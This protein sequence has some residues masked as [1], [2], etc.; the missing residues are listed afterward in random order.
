[1]KNISLSVFF[2]AYNEEINIAKT[3]EQA[4]TVLKKIVKTYEIIIVNDGS[5][6]KTGEIADKLSK[7]DP[8]HI[9]VIHHSP[10][11]GYGAALQ[12][13]FH[14]AK[15][16]Y[17]F[18]SDSDLQ[19]DL[20]EIEKLLE[21]IPKYKV[22]IG[23]R[24]PRRDPFFRL[25]NAALWGL[26][27]RLLFGL[28]VKDIDCAFKLIHRE[29]VKNL[30]M[31]SGGAMLSAEILIRLQNQGIKIKEVPVTHLPSNKTETTGAKPE[32]IIRA[33]RDMWK[34]FNGDLGTPLM[35][36][37]VLFT[38]FGAINTLGDII[39][40]FVLTRSIGW[41]GD[42]LVITKG[43]TFLTMGVSSFFMN[44]SLTFRATHPPTWR[45]YSKFLATNI[46]GLT[47]N[48]TAL[49]I[50]LRAFN[51]MD[52]PA[53]IGAAGASYIWN[54]ST[55]KL[56]VFR[57][58]P[59]GQSIFGKDFLIL[60]FLMVII[61]IN[62][63]IWL[64]FDT[65]P[66][67]WDMANHLRHGLEYTDVAIQIRDSVTLKELARSVFEFFVGKNTYY[68]P[69][70]YWVSVPWILALGRTF[71]AAVLSNIFFLAV[72][73]FSTYT[74]GVRL[75]NRTTGL[76]AT[77]VMLSFPFIVGQFHEFQLDLPL[78]A[79]NL[80]AVVALLKTNR[81]QNRFWSFVFGATVGL[82]MLT[83]WPLPAF[84]IG[85]VV[86]E[87]IGRIREI[88][89]LTG[90]KHREAQQ[91]L[92]LNLGLGLLGW[93]VTAGPWYIRHLESLQSNLGVNWETGTGEGDPNPLSVRSFRLYSD[94][95]IQ[96]QIRLFMLIPFVV[97][98][99]LT[100]K[101]KVN[102]QKN[103]V[104]LAWFAGSYIVMTLYN[105][106][107][108]RFIEPILGSVAILTAF[109]IPQ[110]KNPIKKILIGYIVIIAMFQFWTVSWGQ[111]LLPNTPEW[112]TAYI[113]DIE[114]PIKNKFRLT[115]WQFAGYGSGSPRPENWHQHDILDAIDLTNPDKTPKKFA[116]YYRDDAFFNRE[117]MAYAISQRQAPYSIRD[118]GQATWDCYNV[119]YVIATDQSG[120][121][122]FVNREFPHREG[123]RLENP[124]EYH[125]IPFCNLKTIG[126]YTLPNKHKVTLWQII[127]T[128]PK[129]EPG[130]P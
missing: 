71:E 35:R 56:W 122:Q 86:Y 14:A 70:V 33:F 123:F 109:W 61:I 43:L 21:H 31:E 66:P 129:P 51:F 55:Q 72:M 110:L 77:I 112:V 7:S 27:I 42:H 23:Y 113:P 17:V 25:I 29:L 41:F 1:M 45:E 6:D 64:Q 65:I 39:L 121:D 84:I 62:T 4:Q 63:Y 44:R 83:K 69:L 5:R 126:E 103:G 28:K 11:Q 54:F 34:S 47:V 118:G 125:Q 76:L 111:R 59:T 119:D 22:V 100:I 82:G 16:D 92:F 93:L 46:T 67:H 80:L 105:N 114:N 130:Q 120:I 128:R 9:K 3:V 12:S 87:L 37:A 98:L 53:V 30:P 52:I 91:N 2:P 90:Q 89:R 68:P 60:I 115:I 50:L 102:L 36:Q 79:M 99:F 75:W 88:N 107:D 58:K 106:K 19:F 48:V 116:M 32:V 104:L 127:T 108:Y 15:Y 74:L 13:G 8:K 117:N 24:S 40:Y 81:W 18:F 101:H 124:G 97:G 73:T 38:V 49:F 78:T 95:L 10:N 85:P 94:V 20:N 57:A 96:A 26:A